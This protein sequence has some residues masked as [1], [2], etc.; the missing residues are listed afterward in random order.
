[1]GK[2]GTWLGIWDGWPAGLT[3]EVEMR[4][5]RTRL[6]GWGQTEAL[7]HYSGESLAHLE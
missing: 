1:M 2:S 4:E 5:Q 6:W 3:V 7:T